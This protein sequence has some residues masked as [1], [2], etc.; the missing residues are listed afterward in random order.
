M[1]KIALKKK[2][3]TTVIER[4][5]HLKTTF[6][7]TTATTAT[8]PTGTNPTATP[9]AT[10]TPNTNTNTITTMEIFSVNVINIY[11][12]CRWQIKQQKSR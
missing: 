11:K 7:A 2:F 6:V 3:P 9:T 12:V 5:P 8:A 10:P 4:A 1:W